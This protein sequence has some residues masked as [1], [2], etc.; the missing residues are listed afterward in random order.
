MFIFHI[1][2]CIRESQ[3]VDIVTILD[4]TL[5]FSSPSAD[6]Y[7]EAGISCLAVVVLLVLIIFVCFRKIQKT[8]RKKSQDQHRY[9]PFQDDVSEHACSCFYLLKIIVV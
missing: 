6:I 1:C 8:L 5:F 7:I 9:A 4:S 3:H 2:D